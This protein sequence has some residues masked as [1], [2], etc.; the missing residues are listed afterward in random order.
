MDKKLNAPPTIHLPQHQD[1]SPPKTS[2]EV[3]YLAWSQC[4][5]CGNTFSG[6]VYPPKKPPKF[7]SRD[8]FNQDC[9]N[10]RIAVTCLHCQKAFV[11]KPS[12]PKVYCSKPC[13]DVSR[14]TGESGVTKQCAVCGV[15]FFAR[16]AGARFRP[17][18]ACSATCAK[19]WVWREKPEIMLAGSKKAAL[20]LKGRVPP[21]K[22]KPA[23]AEARAKMRLAHAGS[24]FTRGGNGT[25]MSK[26]EALVASTLPKE[27]V[28][29]HAVPT[30]IPK[31]RGYPTCYKID[32][33]HPTK[34][35]ALEVDGSSHSTLERQGQDRKKQVLLEQLGWKVLRISN[36]TVLNLYGTSKL[37][38]HMT[39]LLAGC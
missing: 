37:A 18:V 20:K 16:L 29:N 5:N 30:K 12:N 2:K 27:F 36:S 17:Q 19:L 32:F 26:C 33:A 9:A 22:G 11:K 10:T 15:D 24:M 1:G 4:K 6:K 28:Y 39:S 14:A 38:D 13:F 23:S 31:G 8:C 25:G 34:K 3:S 35:V 7:C 21:N